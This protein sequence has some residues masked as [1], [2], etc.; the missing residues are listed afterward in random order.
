MKEAYTYASTPWSNH[1]PQRDT[2]QLDVYSYRR[3]SDLQSRASSLNNSERPRLVHIYDI[4]APIIDPRVTRMLHI[5]HF[6][7]PQRRL[8]LLDLEV[9]VSN[10][11]THPLASARITT[12]GLTQT[13]SALT[14]D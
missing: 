5:P 8:L 6:A 14:A 9:G 11:Y 12:G 2:I 1:K 3:R 7:A 13:L 10:V 4:K